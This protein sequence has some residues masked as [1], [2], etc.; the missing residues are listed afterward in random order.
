MYQTLNFDPYKALKS[1]L[2]VTS[3]HIGKDFIKVTAEEIKKLFQADLV[4]ITKALDFNPTTK[5]KVL[6]KTDDLVPDSFEL[7][8][9]P[10][11]LVF[12][13]DIIKINEN[14]KN[15]FEQEK[16]SSFESFFG[17]PINNEHNICI[18]HIAIFSNEKRELPKELEDIAVIYSR[19]IERETKRI[20]LEKENERIRNELEELTITDS[21]TNLYNRRFFTKVNSD[22]FAQVKRGYVRATLA[23]IDLDNFKIINDNFGHEGGDEVLAKFAKIMLDNSRD[24]V[25]NI[26]RIGGEEFCIISLNSSLDYAFNHLE[27]IMDETK[28]FFR[29]TKYGEITLSIGLVQFDEKLK[30]HNEVIKLADKRMYEAKKAG[31][32]MIYNID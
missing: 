16:S 11:K 23:Y 28:E 3:A 18:G 1:I 12:E 9:A 24:G 4:F 7:E 6:Y 27:R 10:C 30:D 17:V 13:N 20:E 22:I 19:K 31:K 25:D 14:V 2:E 29:N 8:G 21:L 5:V 15:T 32:N 26:F